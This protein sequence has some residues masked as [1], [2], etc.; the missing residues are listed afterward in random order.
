MNNNFR[1]GFIFINVLVFV[2][3]YA[4]ITSHIGKLI[5]LEQPVG[6]ILA[7]I[8][9]GISIYYYP[10]LKSHFGPSSKDK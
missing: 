3:L 4:F 10:K 7:L 2:F 1:K 9:T 8:P 5:G 6:I